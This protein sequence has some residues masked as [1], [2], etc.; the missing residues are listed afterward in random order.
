MKYSETNKAAL[1][2]FCEAI[3]DYLKNERHV[4]I[5]DINKIRYFF[6]PYNNIS[7]CSVKGALEI[8]IK[9][10]TYADNGTVTKRSETIVFSENG[11]FIISNVQEDFFGEYY[12]N[13]N[14]RIGANE[15][16][17]LIPEI[18]NNALE[19]IFRLLKVENGILEISKRKFE[20]K[21]NRKP[22]ISNT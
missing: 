16:E 8:S 1:Y 7:D 20:I 6:S 13:N 19:H 12:N 18:L 11:Y 2:E 5:D 14:Y 15:D 22:K 4:I 10:S 3:C 9:S 17:A 21:K